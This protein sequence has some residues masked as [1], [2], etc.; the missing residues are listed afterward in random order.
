MCIKRCKGAQWN[1]IGMRSGRKPSSRPKILAETFEFGPNL[2][3]AA[4]ISSTVCGGDAVRMLP[5]PEAI[6]GKGGRYAAICSAVILGGG[7]SLAGCAAARM[8]CVAEAHGSGTPC[9]YFRV[10]T[11]AVGMS[12]NPHTTARGTPHQGHL[13]HCGTSVRS[14]WTAPHCPLLHAAVLAG[15][16]SDPVRRLVQCCEADRPAAAESRLH[17]CW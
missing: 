3:M 5:R 7:G 6:L 16:K 9:W 10:M 4:N 13:C 11:V 12:S 14:T 15:L 1:T 17:P 8:T 2:A